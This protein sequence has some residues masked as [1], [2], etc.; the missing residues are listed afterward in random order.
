MMTVGSKL[1]VSGEVFQGLPFPHYIIGI[2]FQIREYF[3]FQHKESPVYP[4]ACI[5]WLLCECLYIALVIK[6]HYTKAAAWLYCS[7]GGYFARLIMIF[8]EFI[9]IN[10][11]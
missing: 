6:L 3:G 10:M 4:G 11:R 5:S 8:N 1:P 2:V 7:H 9:K